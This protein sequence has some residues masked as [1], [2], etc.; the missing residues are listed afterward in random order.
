M[1]RP[2]ATD[3]TTPD[4]KVMIGAILGR[5]LAPNLFGDHVADIRVESDELGGG[6]P[7]HIAGAGDTRKHADAA[8]QELNITTIAAVIGHDLDDLVPG[9]RVGDVLAGQ[10]LRDHLRQPRHVPDQ[11]VGYGLSALL[12][13]ID[14]DRQ[15]TPR[16]KEEA[17]RF[18]VLRQGLLN[19]ADLTSRIMF[20]HLAP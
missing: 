9:R 3:R 6:Q 16:A 4:R 10:L 14:A 20:M 15:R 19:E 12:P 8:E 5:K 1:D 2:F 11:R 17:Y 7:T 18:A 13:F